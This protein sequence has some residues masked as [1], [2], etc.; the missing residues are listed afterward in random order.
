[1]PVTD[2]LLYVG[3]IKMYIWDA[4]LEYFHIML[5]HCISQGNVV[6]LTFLSYRYAVVTDSF[7]DKAFK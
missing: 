5:S 6:L 7:S 4:L 3:E 2:I 1:M